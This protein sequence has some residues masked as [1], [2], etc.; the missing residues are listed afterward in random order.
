M[1][2]IDTVNRAMFFILGLFIVLASIVV[3]YDVIARYFFG[4][5]SKFGFDLSIWLTAA[6]AFLGGGYLIANN[7]HIR[8]DFFYERFST[9]MKGCFNF[10]T[11]LFVLIMA[12][13]FFWLGGEHVMSL[14][15]RGSIATSGFNIP[16]WVKWLIVPAGA[17][18]LGLQTLVVL[19]K[20]IYSS[21]TGKRWGDEEDMPSEN[22]REEVN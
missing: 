13:L 10:I 2:A 12:I 9:G 11:H 17:L 6:C 16:L 21:V 1:N 15:T 3:F 18:L 7:G 19:V 22:K 20:E 5:S 4:E 14:Y 8:V